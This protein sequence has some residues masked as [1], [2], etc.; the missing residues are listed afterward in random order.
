MF[1]YTF[2]FSVTDPETSVLVTNGKVT[3]FD[4]T[5]AAPKIAGELL[6]RMTTARRPA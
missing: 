6:K 1:T 2:T 4:G 5:F 3:A